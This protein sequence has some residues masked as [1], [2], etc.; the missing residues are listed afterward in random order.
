M[1]VLAHRSLPSELTM[2]LGLCTVGLT[3]DLYSEFAGM[4]T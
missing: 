2:P 3:D 1:A 4:I